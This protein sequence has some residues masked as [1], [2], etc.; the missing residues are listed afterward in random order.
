MSIFT[1]LLLACLSSSNCF[2]TS[3]CHCEVLPL[4]SSSL[5]KSFLD[6]NSFAFCSNSFVSPTLFSLAFA[7]LI[8]SCGVCG[9]ISSLASEIASV[10]FCSAFGGVVVAGST[11]ALASFLYFG[12]LSSALLTFF[13][14]MRKFPLLSLS[15]MIKFIFSLLFLSAKGKINPLFSSV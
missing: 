1:I 3:C 14:V 4:K 8:I 12:L 13:A 5:F 9:I 2:I 7:C 11:P 6:S 15:S 10:G